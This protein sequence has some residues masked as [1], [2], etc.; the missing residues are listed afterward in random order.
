MRAALRQWREEAA[1]EKHA[2]FI[3]EELTQRF[4][5]CAVQV[6]C[7]DVAN[8]RI[9]GILTKEGRRGFQSGIDNSQQATVSHC[10]FT[11]NTSQNGVLQLYW[12]GVFTHI[13]I[14]F[15]NYMLL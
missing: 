14:Y 2:E 5:R 1:E 6:F 11:Y 3:G 4:G 15:S 8:F 9:V 10:A 12:S 7:E 13:F